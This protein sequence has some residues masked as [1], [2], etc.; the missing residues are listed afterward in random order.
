MAAPLPRGDRSLM[1][2]HRL[3][4][5]YEDAAAAHLASRGWEVV[6]RNVRFRR[7]EIDLVVR[8]GDTVAFV[9]VKGRRGAGCGHP[10]EAVTPRKRREIEAVAAW[11]VARHGAEGCA[12][13]FDAVAVLE[14]PCGRLRVEHVPDAWRPER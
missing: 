14:G 3:G 5:R 8:S 6:D 1:D 4:R 13:R 7:R 9:E 11:W 10:L 2:T 12:Y